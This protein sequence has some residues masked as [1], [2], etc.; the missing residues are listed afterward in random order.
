[1]KTRKMTVMAI[2][3]GV[4]ALGTINCGNTVAWME[5]MAQ[6]WDPSKAVMLTAADGTT[7]DASGNVSVALY[8]LDNNGTLDVIVGD[9]AGF[10]AFG[11]NPSATGFEPV[12]NHLMMGT[13]F[14]VP[15]LG[16]NVK[17]TVGDLDGDGLWELVVGNAAGELKI[18]KI[19]DY[20]WDAMEFTVSPLQA[21]GSEALPYSSGYTA[22]T[23]GDADNDGD[24]D[25]LVGAGDGDIYTY[26]NVGD[27]TNPQFVFR[28]TLSINFGARASVALMN[29]DNDN[30][31]DYVVGNEAGEIYFCF[32]AI[33]ECTLKATAD[34]N[35]KVAV[36]DV[37]HDGIDDLVYGTGHGNVWYLEGTPAQ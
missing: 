5:S 34:T 12:D 7:V 31:S 23:L 17:P 33:N 36:G 4:L 16:R 24:L 14:N 26:E 6:T 18:I 21:E 20:T 10:V 30:V 37:N 9:S 27:A 8:D 13:N 3:L 1:M 25:L 29:L 28:T 35:V 2:M 19:T 32:P 22:P 15:D 11:L